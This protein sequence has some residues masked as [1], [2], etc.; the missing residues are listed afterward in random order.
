MDLNANDE[1][2]KIKVEDADKESAG[3]SSKNEAIHQVNFKVALYRIFR[4]NLWAFPLL[5]AI[6]WP[7]LFVVR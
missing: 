3:P 4:A 2:P 1:I 7:T 5:I 6:L